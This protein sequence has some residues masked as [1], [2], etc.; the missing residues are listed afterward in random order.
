MEY[1]ST[2]KWL[3]IDIKHDYIM[4]VFFFGKLFNLT[5]KNSII[6]VVFLCTG[7]GNN[8]ENW[9]LDASVCIKHSISRM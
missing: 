8:E 1:L 3:K 5:C 2:L 6:V 9:Y 7:G 4:C